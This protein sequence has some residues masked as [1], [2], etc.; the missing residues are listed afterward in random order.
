VLLVSLVNL[1]SR[2]GN[3]RRRKMNRKQWSNYGCSSLTCMVS[4][5]GVSEPWAVITIFRIA[6]GKIVEDWGLVGKPW[7]E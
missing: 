3:Q 1:K 5:L 4:A 2:S 6:D 7:Y